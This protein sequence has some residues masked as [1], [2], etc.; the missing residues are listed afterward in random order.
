MTLLC[1][2]LLVSSSLLLTFTIRYAITEHL[3]YYQLDDN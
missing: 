3:T 2:V 1:T